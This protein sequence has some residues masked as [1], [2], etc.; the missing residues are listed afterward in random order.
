M[1][2]NKQNAAALI[3]TVMLSLSA[4]S[5][6]ADT[7]ALKE[8]KD[9]D[10][11]IDAALPEGAICIPGTAHCIGNE[12]YQCN[13]N[14]SDW[15]VTSCEQDKT[16]INGK[17]ET[18]LCSPYTAKCDS[19]TSVQI[20]AANGLSWGDPSPCK[21]DEICVGGA[22]MPK[23]CDSG[24]KSCVQNKLITCKDDGSGYEE[25]DCGKG[26]LCFKDKCIEC[27]EDTDCGDVGICQDGLC[28]PRNLEIVTEELPDGSINSPYETVL[29]AKYG[30]P[31][32]LWS[33]SEGNLP[34]G[35]T[36][37]TDSGKID[38]TPAESGDFEFTAKVS[39]SLQGE[40]SRTFILKILPAGLH[41]TTN[42]PLPGAMEGE[43]YKQNL[44]AVGGVKPYGWLIK[45]GNLPAGL[46]LESSGTVS[47]IPSQIGD[48]TFNIKVVDDDSP[49]GVDSKEFKLNVKVAP[50]EITADTIYNV[51]IAKIVILP[52]ITIIEGFPIPYNTQLT[53]KGG[54]KPYHW[55]EQKIPGM[56]NFLIPK[57]GIPAGLTLDDDGK[58]HGS[59]TSTADVIEVSIPMTQIKLKGFF[60]MGE[61]KDS[62]NP[63]DSDNGIFLI[64]TIPLSDL[65]GGL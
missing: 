14:G 50:L 39:D 27:V 19:E 4:L 65:A 8:N 63:A 18:L 15:T 49:P 2:E 56:L 37:G 1:P 32:Y 46:I 9:A 13:E 6:P 51:Y 33:L 48:F 21:E 26:Q 60:F 10:I 25:K 16:C 45:N 5:C 12:I 22:C 61:V 36:L 31:P 34:A 3:L 44:N 47:G 57:S 17:C 62:Q 55:T 58:L 38:G 24:S 59:V 11:I 29:E 30:F 35:L 64:P 43:S 20:C 54:L 23:K 41:I 28:V 53:A 7:I 52:M 40:A 42:S